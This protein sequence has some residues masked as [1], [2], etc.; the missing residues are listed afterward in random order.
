MLLS[1]AAHVLANHPLMSVDPAAFLSLSSDA[2]ARAIIHLVTKLRKSIDIHV[3]D[4]VYLNADLMP[5]QLKLDYELR[6][7]H[8]RRCT[9]DKHDLVIRDGKLIVKSSRLTGPLAPFA[10]I[11]VGTTL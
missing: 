10:H 5:E 2:D 9:V 4:L 1:F 11:T 7:E 6:T 8:K 3:H